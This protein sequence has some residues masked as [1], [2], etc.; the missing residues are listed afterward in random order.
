MKLRGATALVTG[1]AVRIGRAIVEE[2]ADEGCNVVIHCNRSLTAAETLARK[3]KKRGR[4]VWVVQC[5]LACEQDCASLMAS[6]WRLAGRVDILVNNA[7]VFHKDRLSAA[8]EAKLMAELRVNLLVPILLTR[9]FA[10]RA[11]TGS[12]INLL[13]RRIAAIDAECLPYWLSKKA[14][15]AFTE[16]AALELAPRITVNGVAPGPVL[17]PPGKGADYLHDKMGRVPMGRRVTPK[18]VAAAV[19]ALLRLD[20][21]TGQIVFVDGGQHL[22]GQDV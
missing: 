20:G 18:E 22:L 7:S 17:P 21:V 13:D 16:A 8:S 2:L 3:L 6:A 9:A 10:R 15:A 5:E 12:V 14:L 19:T 1:G 4:G 11:R